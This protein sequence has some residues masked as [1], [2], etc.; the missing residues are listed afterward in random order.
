MIVNGKA[1][2][3]VLLDFHQVLFVYGIIWG[4]ND[5][6]YQNVG[7]CISLGRSFFFYISSGFI[8]ISF[9]LDLLEWEIQR[10]GASL[11]S[12]IWMIVFILHRN[13]YLIHVGWYTEGDIYIYFL[14]T[15]VPWII[16]L[17]KF[18]F[19]TNMWYT[20]GDIYIYIL[21]TLVPWII[22][23]VKFCFFTNM[24]ETQVLAFHQYLSPNISET[25][26]N[27]YS[28]SLERSIDRKVHINSCRNASE[29]AS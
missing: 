21:Y 7:L 25:V 11:I 27:V 24:C 28:R 13:W 12:C 1:C 18:C 20:E 4:L 19:F 16:S 29:I 15:L 14:Y 26:T 10:I 23:L 8:M 5:F 17:V 22:S 6:F 9:T 2:F 3:N